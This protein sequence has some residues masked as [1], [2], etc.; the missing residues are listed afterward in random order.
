M[1]EGGK[2]MWK[3]VKLHGKRG[4]ACGRHGKAPRQKGESIW[5]TG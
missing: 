4:K 5:K 3:K 2:K 1:T